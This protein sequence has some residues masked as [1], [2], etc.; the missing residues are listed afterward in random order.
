VLAA[1]VL[2][3]L[4]PAALSGCM[5]GDEDAEDARVRSDVLTIYSSLPAHGVSAQAARAV[6]AGQELALADA[7]GRAAGRR[8]R[9]VRLDSTEP[10]ER[11]WT[12]ERVSANAERAAEDDTTIAYLGELDYGASAVSLPITNEADLLQ[13]SPG[14]TL[15]SLTQTPP[16]KPRAGP[17]R[18][19]PS[20]R[21]TFV[22]LLPNDLLLAETLL[23]QVRSAGGERAV[24]VHDDDVASRE[25]GSQ[26]VARARRDG[27]TPVAAEE[28]QGAVEDVPD[29]A[30]GLAEERPGVVLYAG[31]AGPAT[32]P[33]LAAIDRRLPGVPVFATSGLLARDP[34]VP[35]PS[36]P[37]RVE[38]LSA[39]PPE[40]RLPTRGR[41]M[42]R[43]IAARAG[44]ATA[45]PEALL[46][47]ESMRVAL[48]AI[49]A[50]GP[51]RRL[52]A[53][54]ALRIRERQSPLGPYGVRGTGDVDG[55]RFAAYRLHDGRFGFVG[56][57]E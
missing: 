42:L 1:L 54:E 4:A 39:V 21:R 33:L 51:D 44:E 37:E 15:T 56:M 22:R 43:R 36:A 35:I 29:L 12:P 11:L 24:V 13:V 52:V 27:P 23:E 45:R 18:Y 26:L 10:G 3:A 9:L 19:Y 5:G 2:A 30:R 31:V 8:V 40:S 41:R 53:H 57:L 46:G 34:R 50:A 14:D 55:E 28:F 7:G 32:G 20:E 17:D 47:Y 16:G 48:D 6:G 49:D 38:A 25:L